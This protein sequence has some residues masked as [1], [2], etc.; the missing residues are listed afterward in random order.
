MRRHDRDLFTLIELLVVIAIIAMLASM[1][2]P[3]LQNAKD[4]GMRASC[5]NNLKQVGLAFHMY[6]DDQDGYMPT[7]YALTAVSPLTNSNAGWVGCT[8][9]YLGGSVPGCRSALFCPAN[10]KGNAYNGWVDTAH[11][12]RVGMNGPGNGGWLAFGATYGDH[13]R[14]NKKP[15]PTKCSVLHEGDL[16][17]AGS[18][19]W[20]WSFEFRHIRAMNVLFGDSHVEGRSMGMIYSYHPDATLYGLLSYADANRLKYW[21]DWQ[22]APPFIDH[23]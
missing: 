23:P 12:E 7:E 5:R 20:P 10:Q 4:A 17:W 3:A 6:V 9:S 1:L 11:I 2:L 16:S 19:Y 22:T 13:Q 8:T 18:Y 14:L 15:D 21:S